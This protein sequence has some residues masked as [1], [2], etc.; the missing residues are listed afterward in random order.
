MDQIYPPKFLNIGASTL[1]LTVF[2]VF[3]VQYHASKIVFPLDTKGKKL[4]AFFDFQLE[5]SFSKW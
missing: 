2:R 3:W 1:I 4:L 5:T